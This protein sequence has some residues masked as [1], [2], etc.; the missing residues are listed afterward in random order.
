M[1]Q[2]RYSVPKF[3]QTLLT[4]AA[5]TAMLTGLSWM[6]L[7]VFNRQLSAIWTALVALLFFAFV[8]APS[9]WRYWRG[10]IVLAVLPTGLLDTRHSAEPVAWETIREIVLRQNEDDFRLDVYLWKDQMHANDNRASG[11]PRPDFT[12]EVAPLDAS[13]GDV[14]TA[15]ETHKPVRMEH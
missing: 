3:R 1:A 12:I 8:S 4:S 14:Y 5:L 13:L 7:Q 2:F 9:I 15:I 11:V 10:E 6:L